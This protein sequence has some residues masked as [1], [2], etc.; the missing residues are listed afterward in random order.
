MEY[1]GIWLYEAITLE[2]SPYVATL[3][4]IYTTSKLISSYAVA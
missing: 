3:T 1:K 4:L 2:N